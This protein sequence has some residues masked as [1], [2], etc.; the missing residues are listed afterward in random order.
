MR[1]LRAAILVGALSILC[2][3]LL[4]RLG[5]V[6]RLES[7]ALDLRYASGLGRK[8]ASSDI[9]V[10]W[11]DQ[12]SMDFVEREVGQSFP[13]S[14]DVYAEA[15][16]WLKEAGA[17]AVVFDLLFDQRVSGGGDAA[18]GEVLAATPGSAVGFKFVS[19]RDG[20]RTPEETSA[21]AARALDLPQPDAT[22]TLERGVVLPLD[23]IRKGGKALGFVN[24]RP[25]DDKVYRH[26]DVLRWL[27]GPDGKAL[28][29]PSL[30]LAGSGVDDPRALIP[31]SGPRVL[32]N[33]RGPEFSYE[34]VKFVNLLVSAGNEA[35]GKPPV[36]PRERFKD[37]VVLIG[38]NAEGYEDIHPVPLSRVFPGV[39]L[40]ATAIDNLRAKD[41]LRESGGGIGLAALGAVTATLCVFGIPGIGAAVIALC[42]GLLVWLAVVA[43]GWLQLLV[44]PVAAPVLAG[45]FASGAGFVWRVVVEGRQK[46]EMRRAFSSYMAPEVLAEVL[47]DPKNLSLGGETREV[48]LLF[49]DLAGFTALAEHLAPHEV[50]AFLNDYF[51]RMCEPILVEG[52]VIDKFIGD[53]IMALFGAP[54]SG[55]D[56]ASRALRAALALREVSARIGDELRRAGRPAIATR[57]GVHSG[58]AVVGNMGSARRFDYTAIG[59]TVNLASRLEGAGKYFG[60]DCLVSASTRDA[61]GTDVVCRE[62]GSIAVKGRQEALRV[63]QPIA[64]AGRVA[65][66]DARRLARHE[67][68]LAALRRGERDAALGGFGALADDGSGDTLAA[69]YVERLADPRWDGVFRLDAK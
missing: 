52:G 61:A 6:G 34:H 47:K 9:V 18:F 20:G 38:I 69:L 55:A 1:R 10:A 2:V 21:F 54:L 40:H 15:L 66:A 19:F 16:A 60:V 37:K 35:D 42:A 51:T 58:A 49:T 67:A 27:R 13:W 24:V 59:D 32:L 48:T 46:R 62:V 28:A 36:Y 41:F 31:A 25:D 57:I 22:I 64:L 39:E 44:L 23:E 17:R 68:A 12:E 5:L 14:R 26:Y 50:V 43:F 53:A 63:F 7:I 56:H 45:A 29:F 30:A 4:D 65:E 8:P 33:F 3:F 11:I